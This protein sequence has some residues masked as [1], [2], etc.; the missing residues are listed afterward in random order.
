MQIN[1]DSDLID[2]SLLNTSWVTVSTQPKENARK[3]KAL[4]KLPHAVPHLI[5]PAYNPNGFCASCFFPP[6]LSAPP[7]AVSPTLLVVSP[8]PEVK[9]PTVSPTPLP[10]LP[11]PSPTPSKCISICRDMA[12]RGQEA[13]LGD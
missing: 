8:M 7:F 4:F 10:R 11:T 5:S 2:F 3:V 12:E 13:I 6:I 1:W 9:P